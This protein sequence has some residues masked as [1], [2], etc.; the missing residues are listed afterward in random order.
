MRSAVAYWLSGILALTAV[1]AGAPAAPGGVTFK[2]FFGEGLRAQ[3][4]TGRVVVYLIREGS[5]LDGRVAPAD[6]PFFDDPQPMFGIDVK[7]LPPGIDAIV[8]DAAASFPVRL[9][10]LPPGKYKAQAVL[11]MHQDN[12]SWKREPGNLYSEVI[13]F[14]SRGQADDTAI[15]VA[16]TRVVVAPKLNLPTGVELFEVRSE[17]L[18]KFRG[19]DVVLRAGVVTPV[20][21]DAG[22]A[23]P[24]VFEVPGFGGD[25]T[26]ARERRAAYTG[27]REGT[28]LAA[29]ARG[30]FWIVLD[31]EG[32]NGHHL[33]ADSANN[34]PVGEALVK[35]LIPALE[36]KYNLIPKP[37]ARLLRGHSSGGWSTLWLA[38][39]YPD[40][41]AAT[42]STSPD[43]VDF[44]KF[45][46]SNIYS[47]ANMYV[48]IPPSAGHG[49]DSADDVP[50]V[51]SYREGA[52][53]KMTVRQENRMEEVIGPSNTSGQQWDS[54]Q[55]V[56]GPRDASGHPAE[57]Y[58]HRIGLIDHAVADQYRKYDIGAL[59]RSNP[60]KYGPII[61]R[62]VHILVGAADNYYLNE[63]V[64]LLK[65]DVD[66]L[67]EIGIPKGDG[68]I[69]VL[70]GFDH[71]SIFTSAEMQAIP[72]EMTAYL[73]RAGHISQ[74]AAGAK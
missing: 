63:A 43:P 33:F 66:H 20:H 73:E 8:G 65:S 54:W 52:E 35:E 58:E 37:S 26:G 10:E 34:G 13:S 2:V 41:F 28:A 45:Q 25:F 72:A 47:D 23:Y 69:R 11:D 74:G 15:N 60:E 19:R 70:P 64:L 61:R 22:R 3:P 59:L 21:R 46:R 32:P 39:Q 51:S 36:A 62:G 53:S 14:Q 31:P 29:L 9:G 1:L 56:F 67:E 30:A 17:L 49:I 44:R 16:L 71:G 5:A 40:V 50:E 24:A 55:A 38:L 42:W 12:S 6:G 68:Y 18:S 7:D 57:L 4:A 48:S 27:A